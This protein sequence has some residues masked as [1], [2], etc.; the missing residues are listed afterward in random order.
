MGSEKKRKMIGVNVEKKAKKIRDESGVCIPATYKSK[1]YAQWK[2][3]TKIEENLNANND[4]DS[5]SDDEDIRK[6]KCLQ[7]FKTYPNTHWDRHNK[8]IA[9]RVKSEL[10]RPDQILKRCKVNEQS[11]P[12]PNIVLLSDSKAAISAIGNY[13]LQPANDDIQQCREDI[14]KLNK[15]VHLQWIPSHCGIAG[16]E[17]AEFL[18]KK[19]T[20]IPISYSNMLPFHRASTN[21]RSRVRRRFHKRLEDQIKDKHWKD[22][23]N[24]TLPEWLRREAVATFRTAVGHDCLANHLH[25]LGVLSSPHCMLCDVPKS[26]TQTISRLVQHFHLP[27][28]WIVAERTRYCLHLQRVEEGGGGGG[29]EEEEEEEEG[30]ETGIFLSFS[31]YN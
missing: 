2:E 4:S 5:N 28:L 26:W 17:A 13:L 1:R 31:E 19:G 23:L 8:K 20:T 25:R 16:N 30:E 10:R 7:G 11:F 6:K 18:A 22:A 9:N 15:S 24:S 27:A 21:I 3:K 29:E 14:K 12:F